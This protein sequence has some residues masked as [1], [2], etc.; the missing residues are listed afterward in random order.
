MWGLSE[1]RASRDCTGYMPMKPVLPG[2]CMLSSGF[3]LLY[4]GFLPCI[5]RG[6]GCSRQRRLRFPMPVL[7]RDLPSPPLPSPPFPSPGGSW[8]SCSLLQGPM[9]EV[10]P[11]HAHPPHPPPLPFVLFYSPLLGSHHIVPSVSCPLY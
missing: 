8:S 3:A 11:P 1:D 10:S 6:L 7:L 9:R 2:I 4:Q 5:T